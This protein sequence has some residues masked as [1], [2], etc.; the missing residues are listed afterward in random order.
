MSTRDIRE[1]K[2]EYDQKCITVEEAARLIRD[3]D[4]IEMGYSVMFPRA[5]DAALAA[6]KDELDHVVVRNGV[7][8]DA[9][10]VLETGGP[11]E[12]QTWHASSDVR[13][14][15]ER[16][17]ANHIPIK[18][19]EMPRY[20]A[21]NLAVDAVIFTTAEMDRHGYFNFGLDGSH[22]LREAK[23]AKT[24][25]LEVNPSQPRVYGRCESE[26]HLDDVDYIVEVE[27]HPLV[28]ATERAFGDIDCKIA[29]LV[30]ERMKDGSTLQL[31]I[32]ALPGAV[33]DV[34]A[35]SSLKDLGVHTEL[36]VD[37]FMRIAK[38]GKIT[39]RKK[40]LDVGR[41]VYAF[42]A[43][44]QELYDFVEDNPEFMTAPV[45]Y[46]N[47]VSI[48]AQQRRMVSINTALH[49][50]LRGEVSSE[51]VGMRHI[52]GAGGQ[53]DFALGSYLAPEGMSF[54]C[55]HASHVDKNGKRTSNIVPAFE[56][57]TIVTMPAPTTNYVV[58]EYGIVNLKGKST[59]ERAR[60]LISIAHPE[61][62]DELTRQAM[63]RGVWRA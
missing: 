33:G 47:A 55:L 21:E 2:K 32:G 56:T 62:R 20:M 36:Y 14:A 53:M 19:S 52:S 4:S 17:T 61:F 38:A 63:E 12:W 10:R 13:R 7:L 8:F 23:K 24:V 30:V 29:E 26:I 35:Q 54:I 18:F 46:V 6:R 58:T 57:G 34:I 15:I 40:T 41:Q 31:G 50:N 28:E 37:S 51:T 42:L 49:V 43:G 44:T 9:S 3:G 60:A 59:A 45:D 5:F 11:F 1:L 16:G 22:F 25:I 27:A 39:G 48:I